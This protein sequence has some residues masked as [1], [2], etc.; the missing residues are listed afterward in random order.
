MAKILEA[1]GSTTGITESIAQTIEAKLQEA[2]N[3]VPVVNAAGHPADG[4]ADGDD[5]VLFGPLC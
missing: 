4:L 2:G 5:A 1:Y 3:V